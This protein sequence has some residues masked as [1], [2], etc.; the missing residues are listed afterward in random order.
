MEDVTAALS[1]AGYRPITLNSFDELIGG[2]RYVC[3]QTTG[4]EQL[5]LVQFLPCLSK[6]TWD[7]VCWEDNSALYIS[8]AVR[9]QL[10]GKFNFK[11]DYDWFAK[12]SPKV[13]LSKGYYIGNQSRGSFFYPLDLF[14]TNEAGGSSNPFDSQYS[15]E[16]AHPPTQEARMVRDLERLKAEGEAARALIKQREAFSQVDEVRSASAAFLAAGDQRTAA[17][18]IREADDLRRR[19]QARLD[20]GEPVVREVLSIQQ[21]PAPIAGSLERE[22]EDDFDFAEYSRNRRPV[23]APVKAPPIIK[24]GKRVISLED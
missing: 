3:I 4:A 10:G 7:I 18:Y 6:V 1:L 13:S 9:S 8:S 21:A 19:V 23:T 11:S 12:Y 24:R 5:T 17:K 16:R 22:I 14:L 15:F 20:A 2:V